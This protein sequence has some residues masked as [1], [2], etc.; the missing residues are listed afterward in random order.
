MPL[1][2]RDRQ[3]RDRIDI[4]RIA[5]PRETLKAADIMCQ[6][7]EQPMIIRAGL[8]VRPHF[9]HK[10]ACPT[11]Y[12]G[13]PESTEHLL[14]KLMVAERLLQYMPDYAAAQIEFEYPIPEVNR[15][16]DIMV[17]FPCGWRVAH[18]VQLASITTEVLQQ[19]TKDYLNAGIDVFWWLGK[20]A[21]TPANRAWCEQSSGFS[22][23]L[24]MSVITVPSRDYREI[25]AYHTQ[26]AATF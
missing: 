16:A 2:A 13:H 26:G 14:G 23:S 17:V 18:E 1:I 24:D 3:T 25:P 7:C 6:F 5:N 20:H 21:D 19:R 11:T 9:A 8:I 12:I 4:T 10:A 22:L 15:I